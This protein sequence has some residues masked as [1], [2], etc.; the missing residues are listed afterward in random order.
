MVCAAGNDGAGNNTIGYPAKYEQCIAVTAVDIDKKRADVS[1]STPARLKAPAPC[2]E[3]GGF[4]DVPNVKKRQIAL[5][6]Y[7]A[8]EYVLSY[9]VSRPVSSWQTHV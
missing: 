9:H 7:P 5:P 2:H 1:Q 3:G 6:S 4:S 8:K